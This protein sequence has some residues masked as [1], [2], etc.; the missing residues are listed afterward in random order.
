MLFEGQVSMVGDESEVDIFSRP[1]EDI[2]AELQG[3][4][5]KNE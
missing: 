1:T 5:E 4:F 3:L 2:K